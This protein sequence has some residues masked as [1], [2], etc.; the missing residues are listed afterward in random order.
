MLSGHG[1]AGEY[2]CNLA[3]KENMEYI[4]IGTFL[5]KLSTFMAFQN[6]ILAI[7]S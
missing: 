5:R 2:I 3:K 6:R 1:D 7:Y 4:V